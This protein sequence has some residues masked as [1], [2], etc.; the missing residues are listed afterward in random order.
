[1]TTEQKNLLMFFLELNQID[2][3]CTAQKYQT[4]KILSK[5]KKI[6]EE[7]IGK[8]EKK[9]FIELEDAIIKLFEITKRTYFDFGM[10][11][12]DID[13]NYILNGGGI[14]ESNDNRD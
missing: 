10:S 5:L 14:D 1:M 8:D 13:E 6:T 9:N 2:K 4:F 7:K 12:N 3:G 11:A